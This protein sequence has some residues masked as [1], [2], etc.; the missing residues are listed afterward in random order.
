MFFFNPATSL[1][2]FLFPSQ[3]PLSHEVSASSPRT[4]PIIGRAQIT[5]M[6]PMN[7]QVFLGSQVI[8]P[9][10]VST[11]ASHMQRLCCGGL[12]WFGNG[13]FV[14]TKSHFEIWSPVLEVE[15]SGRC[16]GYGDRSLMNRFMPSWGRGE[17]SLLV[18]VKKSLA[19]WLNLIFNPHDFLMKG[20]VTIVIQIL[21]YKWGF[22]QC[23]GSH[24]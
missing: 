10:F 13:F 2:S 5:Q 3:N 19:I 17:F 23:G 11:L 6:E 20:V 24:Q 18:P 12:L 21:L 16:L 15:P 9:T 4:S 22:G 14:P 7:L 1:S 8:S